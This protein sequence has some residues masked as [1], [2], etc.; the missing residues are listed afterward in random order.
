MPTSIKRGLKTWMFVYVGF[1]VALTAANIG[2]ARDTNAVLVSPGS[3]PTDIS[4]DQTFFRPA[5]EQPVRNDI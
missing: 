5:S 3:L 4:A 2:P 1:V